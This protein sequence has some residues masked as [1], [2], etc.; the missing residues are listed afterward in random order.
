MVP[1]NLAKFDK[2]GTDDK[3]WVISGVHRYEAMKKLDSMNMTKKIV[4]F[5]SDR[6]IVIR[7]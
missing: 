6:K 5:P 1:S 3:F 7:N 4:G 2:E